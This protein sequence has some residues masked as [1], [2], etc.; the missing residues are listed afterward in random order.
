MADKTVIYVV[1]ACSLIAY[2]RGEKGSDKFCSL[3]KNTNNKFLMHSVNLGEVYY[4]LLRISGIEKSKEFFED[5]TKL[6]ID[7]IWT[8]NIPFIEL[9]GKYKTSYRISYADAFALALAEQSNAKVV[10]TDHHEFDIIEKAKVL[11]F[12]WLR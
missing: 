8:L 10:S 11:S 2:L 3:L 4:I 7:I 1:D 6:P 5:V 9:V 12:Y